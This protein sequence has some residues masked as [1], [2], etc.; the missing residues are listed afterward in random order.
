MPELHPLIENRYSPRAYDGT[1]V[2][3][4]ILRTLF[5][6][7]RWGPSAVNAQPWRFI[8]A[9]RDQ[10]DEYQKMLS[11]LRPGNQNWAQSAPVLA[12]TCTHSGQPGTEDFNAM[13]YFDAGLAVSQLVIEALHHGLY[14]RQMGG[15]LRDKIHEIYHLPDDFVAVAGMTIGRPGDISILDEDLQIK[16]KAPRQRRPLNESIYTGRWAQ[17]AAFASSDD[18]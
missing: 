8:V 2:A 14:V 7:A 4:D 15:I 3:P 17:P 1:P 16:A 11:C 9:T 10:P 13:K 18:R 12:I 5:E 6:A